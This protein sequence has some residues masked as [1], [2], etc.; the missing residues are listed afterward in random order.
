MRLTASHPLTRRRR[1]TRAQPPRD[2]APTPINQSI[3]THEQ[4]GGSLRV[5]SRRS[6][7]ARRSRSPRAFARATARDVD[8][9]LDARVST[10][11]SLESRSS[12]ASTC[13]RA[14]SDVSTSCVMGDRGIW[15][16]GG[17]ATGERGAFASVTLRDLIT[18]A[19]FGNA[20]GDVTASRRVVSVDRARTRRA[21][22]T[23]RDRLALAR[24]RARASSRSLVAVR[25]VRVERVHRSFVHVRQR[26]RGFIGFMSASTGA[27]SRG[28]VSVSPP[29]VRLGR[30]R[31]RALRRRRRALRLGR[32]SHRLVLLV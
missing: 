17:V 15:G 21:R 32:P 7:R 2:R 12:V 30:R 28:A 4:P 27:G 31:R 3:T 9:S 29:R 22:R 6:S 24:A 11:R 8:G 25:I 13:A 26:V 19:R 5:P 18:R 16:S 1:I 20:R 10:R 14:S 23:R